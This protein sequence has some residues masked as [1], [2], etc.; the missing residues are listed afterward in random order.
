MPGAQSPGATCNVCL[1]P[2]RTPGVTVAEYRD[3]HE[4]FSW[5]LPPVT[6]LSRDTAFLW[7]TRMEAQEMVVREVRATVVG[8]KDDVEIVL[9]TVLAGIEEG[10]GVTVF[11]RPL[12][13]L[14][15]SSEAISA[16]VEQR[17]ARLERLMNVLVEQETPAGEALRRLG[18]AKID[19]DGPTRLARPALFREGE[20]LQVRLLVNGQIVLRGPV[21]VRVSVLGISKHPVA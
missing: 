10:R 3:A 2:M 7:R 12:S 15:S 1:P 20:T 8:E 19:F 4:I 5:V 13:L 17:L 9:N 21:E 14:V 16:E 6:K 11:E 18:G